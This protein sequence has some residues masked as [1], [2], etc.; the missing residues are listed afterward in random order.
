MVESQAAANKISPKAVALRDRA[1]RMGNII[2][3]N[4]YRLNRATLR[5]HFT[6]IGYQTHETTH[7][8]LCLHQNEPTILVHWFAP[9]DVDANVGYYCIEELK[10]FSLPTGPQQF[11]D[12]HGAIVL[13][14]YPHD[15]QRALHLFGT[16]TLQRYHSLIT[17]ENI[18]SF[19][20][21]TL[22][23][24]GRLYR[25]VCDLLVGES[26]L[27]AGCSFGFLPLLVAERM[28][29]LKQVLGIDVQTEPFSVAAAIA[30][31]RHLTNV[32]FAEAD[33]F[34][35]DIKKLG[36]FDTVTALH[37]IEHFTEPDMY[38]VLSRL[39]E[40]TSRRLILAVPFEESPA[41]VH[42]HQQVF[43]HSKLKAV[44]N[45][46]IEWLEGK[47]RMLYEDCDGGLL[48]IEKF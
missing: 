30:Q 24:F 11:S 2:G 48:L 16:N 33:L 26:F 38:Q 39:L 13:S 27:D 34:S 22:E 23:A 47:G 43:S 36:N 14:L 18:S 1:I 7:F 5:E 28:P 25:R 12:F 8:L 4:G 41:V 19:T 10:M 45:W 42:G 31:E 17:N 3:I 6:A 15:V 44:G 37:V 20:N 29:S 35:E 40:I 46:C 32:R 9:E 21:S